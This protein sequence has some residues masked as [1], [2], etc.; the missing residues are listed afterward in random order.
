VVEDWKWFV[1]LGA[2]RIKV[3]LIL[4]E[5]LERVGL[6]ILVAP[7][8]QN[9]A[10][11]RVL[12]CTMDGDCMVCMALLLFHYCTYLLNSRAYHVYNILTSKHTVLSAQILA[13]LIRMPSQSSPRI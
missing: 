6:G 13:L 5:V 8:S 10:F 4:F 9:F 7:C 3:C 1:G 11:L 2:G 12:L